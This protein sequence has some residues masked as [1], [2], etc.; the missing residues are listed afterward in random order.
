M[1]AEFSI[2][3]L[4]LIYVII[5]LLFDSSIISAFLAILKSTMYSHIGIL[6]TLQR[7]AGDRSPRSAKDPDRWCWSAL[8]KLSNFWFHQQWRGRTLDDKCGMPVKLMG[9]VHLHEPTELL[10]VIIC[11]YLG[12]LRTRR[13]WFATGFAS[14]SWWVRSSSEQPQPGLL[15]SAADPPIALA[16]W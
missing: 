1:E 3:G 8:Q 11:Q 14:I 2:V 16:S 9:K 4:Y 5:S 10:A 6:G 12:V 13:V 7:G 15:H